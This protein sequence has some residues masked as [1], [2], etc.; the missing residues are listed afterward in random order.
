MSD[1]ISREAA[2][3]KIRDQGVLGGDYDAYEREEDV[4]NTLNSIPAAKIVALQLTIIPADKE[5][6]NG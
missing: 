3:S 4:V 1:Y 6:D 5:A 2:I